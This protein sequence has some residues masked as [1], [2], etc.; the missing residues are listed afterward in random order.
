MCLRLRLQV[1]QVYSDGKVTLEN[2][3]NGQHVDEKMSKGLVDDKV[4]SLC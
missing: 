4:P 3:L 1:I 2:F